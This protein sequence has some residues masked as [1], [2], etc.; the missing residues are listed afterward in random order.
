MTTRTKHAFE[1]AAKT[2]APFPILDPGDFAEAGARNI[3][4]ATRAAHACFGGC[5]QLNWEII[6]FFNRRF[7]KDITAAQEFMTA[8][9]SKNAYH[10]QAAFLEDA[11]RDYADTASKMLHMAADITCKTMGPV[12]ER[13][14]EALEELD[15]RVQKEAAE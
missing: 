8:K 6:G 5:A 1:E 14:E 9:T 13:T 11:L 10:A 7:Q 2:T 4:Y 12:E 3:D 15:A